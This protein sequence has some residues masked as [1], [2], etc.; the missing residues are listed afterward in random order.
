MRLIGMAERALEL[1][2]A[3]ARDRVAFGAPLADNAVVRSQ[4]AQCRCDIEQVRSPAN[5]VR[6]RHRALPVCPIE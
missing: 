5:H 3:R 4:I 1:T 2:V 6:V